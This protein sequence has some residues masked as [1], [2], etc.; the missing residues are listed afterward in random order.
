MK[1]S[2]YYTVTYKNNKKVGKAAVTI[3][4]KGKYKGTITKTFQIVPKT[5]KITKLKAT[6]KGFQMA[7]K[8][9]KASITGYQ[10]QYSTS[11]KFTKKTTKVKA[12]KKTSTTK[13]TVRKLKAK[14]KYYV[15]IRTYK[16]VKGRK[17]YSGWS[18]T[19]TVRTGK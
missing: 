6:A 11:K 16:T 17:Y 3:R 1:K 15:R 12:V 19:R 10:I 7:W 4:L 5:T 13:L 2:K 8:K 9:Q 14:K 18:K